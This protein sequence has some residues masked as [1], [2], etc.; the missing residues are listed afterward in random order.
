MTVIDFEAAR[1]RMAGPPSTPQ[2]PILAALDA[3]GVALADH[4][5]TWTDREHALYENAVGYLMCGPEFRFVASPPTDDALRAGVR[6]FQKAYSENDSLADWRAFYVAV[7]AHGS[8]E[9]ARE[10]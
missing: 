5:H 9:A 6:A 7:Q 4:G 10:E 2:N 1:Q 8:P 3:L